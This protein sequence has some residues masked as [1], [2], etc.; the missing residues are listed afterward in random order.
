[1]KYIWP[2]LLLILSVFM[3]FKPEILWKMEHFLSVK[4]GEPSD[5]Y[6]AFMR[7][8]GVFFFLSTIII[9]IYFA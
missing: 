7:I 9:V 6:I 2:I 5:L 1:M 4:G 3:I 8:G